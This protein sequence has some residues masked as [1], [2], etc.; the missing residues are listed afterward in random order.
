MRRF[1]TY[2][3]V[4]QI[5]YLFGQENYRSVDDIKNEW[6]EHTNY[7]RDEMLSFIDFLF[8][9]GYYER[10]LVSSFQFLYKLPDDPQK[11]AILYLIARSYEGM[12]NYTLARRYYKRV[13]NIEP[14]TSIAY[15]ASKYREI[16]SYLMEGD[17]KSVLIKTEGSDDPYDLT[18]KAYSYFQSLKWEDARTL[19]I[20]AEEKFD[21]RHYSKLMVPIYQAIENVSNVRQHSHTKVAL[22]GMF[23]PGGGQFIL[24][25]HQNGRGI[26]F[27]SLLLYGIYSLGASTE[28]NGEVQFDKS[29]GIVMPI[30]KG[31]NSGFSLSDGNLTK[32]ISAKSALI[33]YTIP[34]I[35]FGTV[36]HIASLVKS[37][38]DTKGKNQSLIQYYAF[39]SMESISPQRF[40]D[41][42][43]P[44]IIDY[45][46]N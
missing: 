12:K 30:Y 39:E 8:N 31:I 25:D 38:S 24:K 14:E 21:H 18:L 22:S 9:E 7:Q 23:L 28:L 34:P 33:K 35:V 27:T 37:F 46:D 1:Y 15:K 3:L 29:P 5:C 6:G 36:L 42:P 40:L 20:S 10:C 41:F 43:E 19:F 44:T 13:M 26:L 16:Y 2:I 11:P 17:N 45:Q 4:F 32:S